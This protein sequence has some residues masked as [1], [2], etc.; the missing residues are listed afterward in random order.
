MISDINQIKSPESKEKKSESLFN[1]VKE[2]VNNVL[3]PNT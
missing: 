3:N 2:A 1:N